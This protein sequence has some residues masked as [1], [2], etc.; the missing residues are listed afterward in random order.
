[1]FCDILFQLFQNPKQIHWIQNAVVFLWQVEVTPT[2]SSDYT[3]TALSSDQY[4]SCLCGN[5]RKT[6][7]WNLA[8]IALGEVL[9]FMSVIDLS[10]WSDVPVV[11]TKALVK[12][13]DEQF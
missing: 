5:E 10:S 9:T 12:Y 3:L 6:L 1:M 13:T 7:R 2:P 8:S 4:T 11:G